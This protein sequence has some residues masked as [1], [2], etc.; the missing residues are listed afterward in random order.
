M[1]SKKEARRLIATQNES[2]AAGPSEWARKLLEKQG[3]REGGGL[4]RDGSGVTQHVRVARREG[5][6]ALGFKAGLTPVGGGGLAGAAGAA[7]A[8]PLYDVAR[9][10]DAF[11][12]AAGVRIGGAANDDGSSDSDSDSS[13]G[14]ARA[15]KK[16]RRAAE[17]A[18][19]AAAAPQSGEFW[20]QLYEATG[21]ARLGMR[22][23][24]EQKG[25]LERAEKPAGSAEAGSVKA[26]DAAAG[27]AA[28][29]GDAAVE[30]GVAAETD[31]Q[32]QRAARRAARK[33]AAEPEL[34]ADAAAFDADD[35]TRR[36]REEERRQA[37]LAKKG[38]F[39]A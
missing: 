24:A 17:G 5:T 2:A 15:R 12:S 26:G 18:A 39:D 9:G 7:G 34:A 1:S 4:G 38:K 11:A 27:G 6:A 20:S 32:A 37:K 13:D 21:G 36:A 3:W 10:A 29:T 16:R 23:R 25:K 31:R 33:A 28:A 19:G 30:D 35:E 22:A 14:G 8:A